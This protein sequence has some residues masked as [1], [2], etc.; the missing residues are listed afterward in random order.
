[1]VW[2]FSLQVVCPFFR[3]LGVCVVSL[4]V[5]CRVQHVAPFQTQIAMT[6]PVL[7]GHLPKKQVHRVHQ[8]FPWRL[9]AWT[10]SCPFIPC[11]PWQIHFS[12]PWIP[13]STTC[14]GSAGRSL[15]CHVGQA[16]LQAP[17]T[18]PSGR[19]AASPQPC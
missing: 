9:V 3:T 6:S 10:L 7:L 8:A 14:L 11:L 4:Q 12:D 15:S 2:A 5:K 17:E 1:M 13:S 19:S 16:F 18:H